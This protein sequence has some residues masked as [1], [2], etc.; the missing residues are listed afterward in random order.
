M[1]TQQNRTLS[2]FLANPNAPVGPARTRLVDVN[3]NLIA[4]PQPDFYSVAAARVRGNGVSV[5]NELFQDARYLTQRELE[6][7]YGSE[8]AQRIVNLRAG[9]MASFRNDLARTRSGVGIA[10]DTVTGVIGGAIG[11]IGGIAALGG[12]LINED[13]GAGISGFT[14]AV[15]GDIRDA[16]TDGLNVRRRASQ[17]QSFLSSL[18][19]RAT[20]E[21]ERAQQGE[22]IASLRR[23]GRNFS[24][25]AEITLSDGALVGDSIAQGVGSLISGG[26]VSGGLKALGRATIS[27]I[28][29][30]RTAAV[31]VSNPQLYDA[32][33]RTGQVLDRARMPLAIGALEGGG[34]YT[35]TVEEIRAMSHDDL[36]A[37]SDL[38]R[39]LI[40]EGVNPERAKARVM[41]SGGLTAAA[42]QTPIGVATGALVSRFEANPFRIGSAATGASNIVREGIEEGIQSGTGQFAQ[43]VGTRAADNNNDLLAGVGEASAK[44]AIAGAGTGAVF[45]APSAVVGTTQEVGRAGIQAIQRGVSN[46][47]AKGEAINNRNVADTQAQT[48]AAVKAAIASIDLT[49][50]ENVADPV[51]DADELLANNDALM[52]INQSFAYDTNREPINDAEARIIQELPPLEAGYEYDVH[53]IMLIAGER[54]K[55]DKY[56]S[57]EKTDLGIL[58]NSLQ[59]SVTTESMG[60]VDSLRAKA[61]PG[62]TLAR[63]VLRIANAQKTLANDPTIKAAILAGLNAT[64]EVTVK[65]VE[66]VSTPQGLRAAR[67]VAVQALWA[68][69]TVPVEVLERLSKHSAKRPSLFSRNQELAIRSTAALTQG[70]KQAVSDAKAMGLEA[71]KAAKVAM[72]IQTANY[73]KT[74]PGPAVRAHYDAVLEGLSTEGDGGRKALEGMRNF[75]QHMANKLNAGNQ[76]FRAR[77][78]GKT[79]GGDNPTVSFDVFSP[80][81][82]GGSWKTNGNSVFA[83]RFS[84]KSI[85]MVQQIGVDAEYVIGTYNKLVEQ[86]PQL[87]LEPVEAVRLDDG[88]RIPAPEVVSKARAEQEAERQALKKPPVQQAAKPAEQKQE[89]TKPTETKAETVSE[90]VVETVAEQPQQDSTLNVEKLKGAPLEA[91]VSRMNEIQAR[92]GFGEDLPND[93][94]NFAKIEAELRVRKKARD[95]E[96]AATT[97][98]EAVEAVAEPEAQP[99]V[100]ATEETAVTP[101]EEVF[102]NVIRDTNGEQLLLDGFTIDGESRTRLVGKDAITEIEIIE[103]LQDA[104]KFNKLSGLPKSKI[105]SVISE[106]YSN[107]FDAVLNKVFPTIEARIKRS[108]NLKPYMDGKDPENLIRRTSLRT[109]NLMERKA[110][111]SV[112][113]TDTVQTVA[114]LALSDWLAQNS[115]ANQTRTD[116]EIARK[117]GIEIGQVTAEVRNAYNTG[118]SSQQAHDSLAQTL[119]QFLGL[120]A[121]KDVG[122]GLTDGLMLSLAAELLD[123]AE[124]AG[125]ITPI[126]ITVYGSIYKENS[127]DQLNPSNDTVE[128]EVTYLTYLKTNNDKLGL[129]KFGEVGPT[130]A[131]QISLISQIVLQDPT[132]AG[133][134]IG[135]ESLEGKR[136]KQKL[137]RGGADTTSAQKAVEL[138][139]GAVP[140]TVNRPILELFR[141]IGTVGV[142]DL[143]ANGILPETLNINDKESKEGQNL[144]FVS[145]YETMMGVVAEMEQAALDGDVS[146]EEIQLFREYAFSSVNRLQQQ[147]QFGDQASKLTREMITPYASTLDMTD[148]EQLSMFRRGIAQAL[149]IK[150]EKLN[151]NNW[152]L[153]LD[154]KLAKPDIAKVITLLADFDNVNADDLVQAL[155]EAGAITPVMVH[156]LKSYADSLDMSDP[157][158]FFT[159]VYVEADGVTDGPTNSLIYMRLGGFDL[160]MVQ[161]LMRGGL[162]FS[163]RAVPLH[164]IFDPEGIEPKDRLK[165]TYELNAD[166]LSKT[167]RSKIRSIIATARY[168][169]GEPNKKMQAA[170]AAHAQDLMTVMNTLLGKAEHFEYDKDTKTYTIGRKQLKNPLTVKVYGSS[171]QGIADK[172]TKD[173]ISQLYEQ[174]SEANRQATE[175]Q[176]TAPEAWMGYM[177]LTHEEVGGD[178][179]ARLAMMIEFMAAMNRLSLKEVRSS[180][181]GSYYLK[182]ISVPG[183]TPAMTKDPINFT[184][185]SKYLGGLRSALKAFYVGP[186]VDT[187][188]ETMG[189]SVQGSK[190]IQTSTNMLSAL[191]KAAFDTLINNALDSKGTSGAEGLSPNELSDLLKKA[192][193]LFPYMEGD[194]ITVNVKGLNKGYMAHTGKTKGGRDREIRPAGNVLD[195]VSA[196]ISIPLPQ[197]AGVAG[198]A[199][200]NISYGDGRMIIEASPGL[201]GGRLMV[202]DGINL[203]L[204][205]AKAN[206]VAINAAVLKTLQTGTPFSDLLKTFSNVA[207]VFD[208]NQFSDAELRNV[209]EAVRPQ[210]IIDGNMRASVE[211]EIQRLNAKLEQAAME[212][213]ARL[214]TFSR[215]HLSS[216]HMAAL[217]APASTESDTGREDLSL[218]GDDQLIADRLNE[219]YEEELAKF[220]TDARLVK[221]N[222]RTENIEPAF[223]K[224]TQHSSGARVTTTT[225]LRELLGKLNLPAQQSQLIQRA[226][227]ALGKDAWTVV[228]GSRNQA[229]AYAGLIGLRV[230]GQSKPF[231]ENDYGLTAHDRK[232]VIVANGSSETLAH[233]LIHAATLDRIVAFFENPQILDPKSREAIVRINALMEEWLG[234]ATE[235][236]SLQ[237]PAIRKAVS[238]AKYAIT[239]HLVAGRQADAVNEFMAWNLA[240]QDL[241]KLNSSIKTVNPIIRIAKAVLSELRA[242]FGLSSAGSDINSNLRFNT[243]LLMSNNLPSIR[244]IAAD[245][246]MYHSSNDRPDLAEIMQ[247]FATMALS[248]DVDFGQYGPNPSDVLLQR[249]YQLAQ[250]VSD[251]GFK[252]ATDE[253]AAFVAVAAAYLGGR[254]NNPKADIKISRYH[255]ELSA[256]MKH[257]N[258]MDIENSLDPDEKNKADLRIDLLEG[259]VIPIDQLMPAFVAL[260]ATSAQAQKIFNR[261]TVRDAKLA[262]KGTTLDGV[263]KAYATRLVNGFVDRTLNFKP[264]QKVGEEIQNLIGAIIK[265]AEKE[266]SLLPKAFNVPGDLV[267]NANEKAAEAGSFVIGKVSEAAGAGIKALQNTPLEGA[268]NS[269][270]KL[271]QLGIDMMNRRAVEGATNKLTTM[272][273]TSEIPRIFTTFLAELMGSNE[274]NQD[275]LELMKQGRAI[276][277]RIRQAY[278][279]TLVSEIT[280]KFSRK[281][282]QE[283]Y[284]AQHKAFGQTDAAA[285]INAGMSSTEVIDMFGN[286]Q[287]IARLLAKHEATIRQAFGGKANAVLT[288][289]GELAALMDTRHPSHGLVKKNA[290]AIAN[291]VGEK[292]V[293]S[294]DWNSAEV[295]AIDAYTSLL[296]IEK[297]APSVKATLAELTKTDRFALAYVLSMVSQARID[298]MDRVPVRLQYN[299]QKGYMPQ[300]QLGSF[301]VVSAND[302]NS[303][304]STGHR[305]VGTRYRSP[306]EELYDTVGDTTVYVA[307]DL[308][309]PDFKQGIM[310]TI[311]STVFGLDAVSGANFDNPSAGLINDPQAV[312]RITAALQGKRIQD[313][314]LSPLY[315][316]Q[317]QIYAYERIVDPKL[318][319]KAL[320]TQQNV[321][322]SLGQWMGRQHEEYHAQ[323]LNNV[324]IERLADM[325]KTA[326]RTGD[327]DSFVDM[328]DLAKSDPVVADAMNLINDRDMGQAFAKMGGKF[329]VRKDLYDNVIGY[330]VISIGDLWT[331]NT[332]VSRE[333][334]QAFANFLTGILGPEAYRRLVVGEKAWENLMGDARVAIVVKSML[335]PALN[336]GANFYQLMANGIGPVQIAQKSAEKLRE[337]HLYAQ[338]HLEYQRLS[339]ELAAAKG[340]KRPDLARRIETEIEKLDYLN[341]RLSIWPLIQAGEFS[342]VTE[343]LSADDLA[344]TSGRIWDHVSKLADKLPPAVKTAGRYALVTKDTAL[345]EGLA[346]AVS[347]TDFVAKAVLYDHMV[348]KQKMD[349]KA[350]LLRITNEFVNYDLLPGR[351]RAKAEAVGAIWFPS[352]K[353]RSIKVAASLMRNNPLH[354][355]LSALV[356]GSYEVGTVM[357]DNGLNL[358]FDG[359]FSHSLGFDNALRAIG[360]NPIMQIFG[361]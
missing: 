162:V 360:L 64:P 239:Q 322:V 216:D 275:I 71:P 340:D 46:L 56:S 314:S 231:K 153:E 70:L 118:I 61:T 207:E 85:R 286:P 351:V 40:S 268:A 292:T 51:A 288:E 38:Y 47:I 182:D 25:E 33:V 127:Y 133:Y 86:N 356:P 240:N 119:T 135:A 24:D 277:D 248:V 179:E 325:W 209:S 50:V 44:G 172:L 5:D 244:Q 353:L 143:F 115:I 238:D 59:E 227:A 27:R 106:A 96:L 75:A 43:N 157:T 91:L 315:D 16:Q 330:R 202:F 95:A 92:I 253:R 189:S 73:D 164:E 171:N 186:M 74:A 212:E 105:A 242:M 256:Q 35:A 343:G 160:N 53:D 26:I 316:A 281:L 134:T 155:K 37:N 187:I 58:I 295:R 116:E 246:I 357:D 261:I 308:N 146:L 125:F 263:V 18:D 234:S 299:I 355:F 211:G 279:T 290:L 149:G 181:D 3:P 217:G 203:A 210:D 327:E 262:A 94:A 199:Y 335:I 265:Q 89:K 339:N 221:E 306:A 145:A 54:I 191:A 245:R 141:H 304:T 359:R 76:S 99:E 183:I 69:E 144:A 197:V 311:R 270:G 151:T 114:L 184:L 326:V 206:G 129:V 336:A 309:A 20:Y 42:I 361:R 78:D 323:L 307:T 23:I 305:L 341:R 224:L 236:A 302:L 329:M 152:N 6:A 266:S 177:F 41:N 312:E 107:V 318:V 39:E 190:L 19:N 321:A 278:R 200:V 215:V 28:G 82:D 320:Q 303:Y 148:P 338:N 291:R 139:E 345:F 344:M 188:E 79:E 87:G 352:F 249:A 259:S 117:I 132:I 111:G 218:L 258:M 62:G 150:I 167:L 8:E 126:P 310:R 331:G 296:A 169:N 93:A 285:L 250:I 15:T 350:A 274:G 80:S 269:Y 166:T 284:A 219:I 301:K 196:K 101:I 97:Q 241:I 163:K 300:E 2:D 271:A 7:K 10:G 32:A 298:E 273:N 57:A 122:N 293:G 195:V 283:E 213:K 120:K 45:A 159:H 313:T 354:T 11:G 66:D 272:M 110:D 165:D 247:K 192:A 156:A 77:T 317:G 137:K 55:S 178:K 36:L 158:G 52:S 81:A 67:K 337:T 208:I 168:K 30:G 280:K 342:Q 276:I 131:G 173:M 88:L 17:A 201:T 60:T 180:L 264:G 147:G 294:Y 161:G 98:T 252:L 170:M 84:T 12:G 109:L 4:Q 34:A 9:G 31:A 243:M 29:A 254:V 102:P 174:I 123:A 333:T 193:F 297:L 68:P 319:G 237:K 13:L 112:G 223:E 214:A 194:T 90:P 72:Q 347:Y 222:I 225:K 65:D 251:Y 230:P 108:K 226:I 100:T 348:T 176:E 130:F 287:E 267:R 233:E 138:R 103:A 128:G 324:L 346:R 124:E 260:A 229:N 198:G 282:T 255:R 21:R 104:D 22:T 142:V 220:R 48:S 1:T 328:A 154:A 204:D 228:V 358:L 332:N 63:E 334:R 232:L 49:P 121:K 235:A 289:A 83:A 140:Q 113:F 349:S 14:D 136:A 205:N 175:A 257:S 185:N